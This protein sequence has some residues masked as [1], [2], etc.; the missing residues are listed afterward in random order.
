M[1]RQWRT[2]L[3]L[4]RHPCPAS[5]EMIELGKKRKSSTRLP[6]LGLL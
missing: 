3:A 6:E 2:L 4:R 1:I 5:L